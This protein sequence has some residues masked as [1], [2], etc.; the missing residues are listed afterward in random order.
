MCAFKK[1]IIRRIDPNRFHETLKWDIKI[2]RF[3][4]QFTFLYQVR[5][6]GI[7]KW[8]FKGGKLLYGLSAAKQYLH[9]CTPNYS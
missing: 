8:N 6:C 5:S 7:L 2:L 3:V 4:Q 1:N 9:V